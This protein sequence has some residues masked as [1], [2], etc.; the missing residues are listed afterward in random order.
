VVEQAVRDARVLGDVADARAVVTMLGE[1]A[2]RGV[3]DEG[4]LVRLGD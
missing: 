2:N 4:A 1:D 3:E